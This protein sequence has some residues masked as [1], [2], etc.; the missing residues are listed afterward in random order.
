MATRFRI[1]VHAPSRGVAEK[2]VDEAFARVAALT[3]IF[4]DYE[5][6][7]ELSRLNNAPHGQPFAASADLIDLVTRSLEISRLTDGAF[8]ISCGPLTRLW[9]STRA[10]KQLPPPDRLAA[11]KALVEWRSIQVDAKARTITLQKPGMLLDAG[12]IAKGYAADAALRVLRDK[13]HLP[14]AIV[15]AGG[16]IAVGEAP[17][18]STAGWPV[19]LR[20]FVTPNAGGAE[21]LDTIHLHQAA[22]S[23]SGDLYQKIEIDGQ[24][25][26]HIVSPV[27]GLGLTDFIPCSVIAP[28]CTTSDALATAMCILGSEK[29]TAI[30]VKLPGVTVRWSR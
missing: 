11:A 27:T 19:K 20:T 2:A 14:R 30:A 9:R 25:Y 28:D 18:D 16:D 12:G 29:G 22:V 13:H 4:S 5:P 26:A 10:R 15:L 21:K 1:S 6:N 17:P 8:D 24:S 23:T 7:S 3:A